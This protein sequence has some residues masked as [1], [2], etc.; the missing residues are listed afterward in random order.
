VAATPG[1]ELYVVEE[2]EL[3][4]YSSE[5][6]H[7]ASIVAN[8][9]TMQT[10]QVDR[11]QSLLESTVPGGHVAIVDSISFPS[12]APTVSVSPTLAGHQDT[13]SSMG[14]LIIALLVGLP[15]VMFIVGLC[16]GKKISEPKESV[17]ASVTDQGDVNAASSTPAYD[18]VASPSLDRD[19]DNVSDSASDSAPTSVDALELELVDGVPSASL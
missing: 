9:N 7:V 6:T 13:D 14:I 15:V 5:N 4:A 10:S 16:I 17:P 12:V 11:L 1:G 8:S 18:R 2:V 19:P 3:Q